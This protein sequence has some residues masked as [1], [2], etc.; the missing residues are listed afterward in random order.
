MKRSLIGLPMALFALGVAAAQ[1]A[2]EN[3]LNALAP[4]IS[5]RPAFA[6][7]FTEPAAVSINYTAK[8]QALGEAWRE[9]T[10][11]G[12]RPDDTGAVTALSGKINGSNMHYTGCAGWQCNT[13][14]V[15]CTHA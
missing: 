14:A 3:T 6:N 2:F 13:D 1:N 7:A 4:P 9:A 15:L 12:A 11:S 5:P 10:A 8:K